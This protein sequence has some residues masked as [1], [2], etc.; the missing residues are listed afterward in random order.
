MSP[1]RRNPWIGP[2]LLPVDI[3]FHPSWWHKHA[4]I[5]FDEDFF[6]HPARRVES[7]K[8]M[9]DVLY[10]K[11]GAYGLGA[12]RGREL[13][14]VGAVHNA[15]GYLLSEMLGCEVL[16]KE[17]AAPQV[18][19]AGRDRPQIAAGGAFQTPAF[20]RFLGLRDR[21]KAKY[22]YLT[23]DV[24]WGGVLNIALDLAG[25][26]VFLGFF[27]DP[28]ETKRQFREIAGV[29][30]TFVTA[31]ARETGS[32]SVSVNRNVRHIPR[33]VFLHSECSHTMIS[34][35]QYEEFLMPLDLDWSRKFRPFGIHYCGKDPHRYAEVFGRIENLD[36][37]DVGWGGDVKKLRAALPGTFLN[38]R[39]DPVALPGWTDEELAGTIV[40]LVEES[41]EPGLTGVCCINLDDRVTDDKIVTILKTVEE[42][43]E[44]HG[45]NA[46]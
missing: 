19:P 38:L 9:E 5:T 20:R 10:Q 2:V 32:T 4:G 34:T 15:A 14:V 11:F 8:R 7:E 29:I 42:L 13:P 1:G 12:D 39:L 37:L 28:E 46:R 6:Y 41:G 21:L 23:G 26:N 25:E 43:R 30:E 24:N 40:R 27:S 33:P 22:G 16:Y 44:R 31:I 45:A 36:F 3:V 17:D 35:G 18:L